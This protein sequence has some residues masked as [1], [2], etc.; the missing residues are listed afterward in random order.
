MEQMAREVM[1]ACYT[2]FNLFAWDIPDKATVS[3]LNLNKYNLLLDAYYFG[4]M[5]S[6]ANLGILSPN[7]ATFFT[8]FFVTRSYFSYISIKKNFLGDFLFFTLPHPRR[9]ASHVCSQCQQASST[10]SGAA[11][12]G[13]CMTSKY[14]ESHSKA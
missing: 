4:I 2:K 10:L 8:D 14:R 5:S 13:Q 6:V 12:N 3:K 7:L 1:L 9:V 11:Q